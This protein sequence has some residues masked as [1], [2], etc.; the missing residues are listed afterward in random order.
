MV[1]A[2]SQTLADSLRVWFRETNHMGVAHSH[3]YKL[4][5]QFIVEE[6]S[7]VGVALRH[8]YTPGG[9]HVGRGYYQVVHMQ[10]GGPVL[11]FRS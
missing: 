2:Q 11:L 10:V 7:L 4:F 3:G 6:E 5:V 1:V 8:S 9:S